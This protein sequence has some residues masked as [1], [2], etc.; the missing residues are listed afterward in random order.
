MSRAGIERQS[1]RTPGGSWRGRPHRHPPR[2]TQEIL[3]D[4]PGQDDIEVKDINDAGQIVGK[5]EGVNAAFLWQ[6]GQIIDLDNRIVPVPG[7]DIQLKHAW[8]INDRGQIAGYATVFPLGAPVYQAGYLLTPIDSGPA[9]LNIDCRVDAADLMI[10][11]QDWGDS[12]HLPSDIDGDGV[13][14]PRDLA[15]LLAD[16]RP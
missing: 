13:V 1:R 7:L 14:G 2:Q 10:M 6:D 11:L 12:P 5:A 15:M 8:A 16:W 9:D 3:D 4:L